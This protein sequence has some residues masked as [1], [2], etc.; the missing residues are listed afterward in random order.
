[1]TS[2]TEAEDVNTYNIYLNVNMSQKIQ[3]IGYIS[4]VTEAEVVNTYIIYI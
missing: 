4:G 2:V 1:M 3:Y